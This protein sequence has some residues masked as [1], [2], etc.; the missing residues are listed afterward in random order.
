M[1]R[2]FG[3]QV[4]KKYISNES[5]LV[6]IEKKI[7]NVCCDQEE[8]KRLILETINNRREGN[9]CKEIMYCLKHNNYLDNREEYKE[10]REKIKEHDGF[11]V[12]P[13]EVDE[14]VLECGKCGSNKTISYTKQT[15][16]GDEAT[17]V[18]ALC[19]ECNN[20]WKM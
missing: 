17:S 8:Y 6:K 18:F 19:Y 20:K 15:R 3:K 9:S 2:N 14:G 7:H 11:L 1:Y 16:S 13:F 10:Y 12:R 4:L 5:N